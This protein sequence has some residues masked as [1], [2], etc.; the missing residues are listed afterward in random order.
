MSYVLGI[1]KGTTTTKVSIFDLA[2]GRVAATARRPTQSF[3]PRPDW[4]EEDMAGTYGNVAAAI[5]EALAT[6]GID[7]AEVAGIG[8]SGHMGG[9]WAIDAEG[10]PAGPAIAWPDGR[11]A[12]LLD[13]WKEDGRV[14]RLFAI[15]GNAP[16]PGL[17]LVLLSWLKENDP[18]FYG[19]IDKVMLAKDYVNY[20]LTGRVATDE[21]DLSFLPCDIRSRAPS[22][23]LFALAGVEDSFDRL[24]PVLGI[25]EIV[26]RV[27]PG[28]AAETGLMAGT[29]VVTGA[30][31]AVAAAIGVG[32]LR[33]GQAVTVIGTSFMNN[34]TVDRPL[35]EP[36]GVG[37]L[38]LM[39]GGRWQR[40][41]ANTGGGSLCLD[42]IVE[43]FGAKAFAGDD[44]FETLEREARAVPPL[45]NGL[46]I[47]PY[48]NTSGMTAPR[49][50]PFARGSIFGLDINTTPA[51]L[52]RAVMEG[53]AFSMIECYG[54]LDAPVEEIRI[55]GGG[56]RSSLWREIC[57]AAMNRPLLVPEAEE[58]GA[59]GVALLAATAA[60][61][62]ASLDDAAR[63]MVRIAGTVRP[64]PRL[65][66]RYADAYPLFRDLGADLTPLYKRRA[67]LL[68]RASRMKD[69][70]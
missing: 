40:L 63:A 12:G 14:E 70:P 61:A 29:P 48:F 53:V 41:M 20:R 10:R 47:H 51:T 37:F 32:A 5:R 15:S 26:G 9:L 36:E 6:G 59:L 28:A 67:A 3:R 16:I 8:V 60:G 50:D 4:H 30:G 43:A 52:V 44:R 2:D 13:R 27:T 25:G 38:F 66:A 18:D 69:V 46:F 21:S 39:P 58:T 45:S 17:P 54:A 33:A 62:Y 55:T 57:A 42:W 1:D 7:P 64:D 49:H 24:A 65:A 31:D 11:A 22:R 23:E 19:R 68:D 35:L 56:A 34:L